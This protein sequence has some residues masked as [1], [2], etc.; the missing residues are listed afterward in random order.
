MPPA[1][2][3]HAAAGFVQGR[4]VAVVVFVSADACGGRIAVVEADGEACVETQFAR[5]LR[6]FLLPN[7]RRAGAVLKLRL[8]PNE[9]TPSAGLP[10]GGNGRRIG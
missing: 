7:R 4:L 2:A 6:K 1:G 8:Q 10:S 3:A 9:P 5:L